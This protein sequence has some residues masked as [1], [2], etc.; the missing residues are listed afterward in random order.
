M[1][2]EIE[3]NGGQRKEKAARSLDILAEDLIMGML[4]VTDLCNRYSST[5]EIRKC[6]R[7]F[8]CEMIKSIEDK[9]EDDYNYDSI[10]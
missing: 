5:N 1:N 4:E 8:G 9:N 6:F 3:R 2:D 10:K 7:L